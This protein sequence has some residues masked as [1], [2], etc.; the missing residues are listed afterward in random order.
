MPRSKAP[1]DMQPRRLKF[2]HAE[3]REQPV[4][5]RGLDD[6]RTFCETLNFHMQRFGDSNATLS[7]EINGPIG[8]LALTQLVHGISE[9]EFRPSWTG[10]LTAN[11]ELS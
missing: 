8:T 4:V 5:S 11:S 1:S 2:V 9:H 6:A 3:P 10:S 7:N